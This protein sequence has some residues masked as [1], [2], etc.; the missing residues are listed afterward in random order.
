MGR[1]TVYMILSEEE[2]TEA[3]VNRWLKT[4]A[5]PPPFVVFLLTAVERGAVLPTIASRCQEI[6]LRPAPR[7][8]VAAALVGPGTPPRPAQQL[9]ALGGG[10]AGG[11]AFAAR[12]AGPD[13]QPATDPR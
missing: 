10:R 1:S 7:G 12:G 11:A 8:E 9:A 13:G 4:L 6:R 5:E 2:P 3:A